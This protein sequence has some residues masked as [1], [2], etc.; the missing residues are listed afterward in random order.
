M[1]DRRDPKY[2]KEEE[3]EDIYE[4]EKP[5]EAEVS[6]EERLREERPIEEIK[7]TARR[8]IPRM[9]EEMVKPLKRESPKVIGSLFDRV[10]FL[11]QRIEE[12]TQVIEDRKKMHEDMTSEIDEDIAEK[13]AFSAKLTDTDEKRN[14]KLDISI[15]RKE[16]RHEQVQF[17][18]DLLELRTEMRELLENYQTEKKI[19]DMFR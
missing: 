18:R 15:L 7:V 10:N 19:S 11:G 9:E 2:F 6:L 8:A 12:T 17:W 16:K 5:K 4:F 1:F 3:I 13:D 14:I